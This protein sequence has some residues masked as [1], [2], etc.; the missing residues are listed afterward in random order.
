MKTNNLSSTVCRW[1]ARVVSVLAL[2]VII[3]IAVVEKMPILRM[4]PNVFAHP[5]SAESL[6]FIGFYS[7][8]G[9]MLA[10]WRWELAGG[11]ISLVGVCALVEPTMQNG[12]VTWFFAVLAAPGVL[13]IASHLLRRRASAESK[14]QSL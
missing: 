14:T 3:I 8:V 1:I 5:L 2:A 10:G 13:Y 6:G 11:I 4:V 9:G 12:R 7:M